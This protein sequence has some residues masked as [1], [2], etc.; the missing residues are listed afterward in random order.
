MV[1]L[2]QVETIVK[3]VDTMNLAT[4]IIGNHVVVFVDYVWLFSETL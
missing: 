4:E 1:L 2:Y 3:P